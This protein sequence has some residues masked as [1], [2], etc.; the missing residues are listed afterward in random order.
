MCISLGPAEFKGTVIANFPQSTDNE[1]KRVLSYMNSVLSAGTS[2]TK[3][4]VDSAPNAMVFPVYGEVTGVL[5]CDEPVASREWLSKQQ[6]VYYESWEDWSATRSGSGTPGIEVAGNY[7]V[8]VAA[9]IEDIPRALHRLKREAATAFPSHVPEVLDYTLES[10]NRFYR[11][12]GLG[13]PQFVLAAFYLP[14]RY[15]DR[16]N[17]V[18]ITYTQSDSV[19]DK[20][21]FPALDYHGEGEFQEYVKRDHTLLLSTN[22][23]NEML[24]SVMHASTDSVPPEFNQAPRQFPISVRDSRNP[25]NELE[26]RA[27]NNDYMFDMAAIHAKLQGGAGGVR[28]PAPH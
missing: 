9:D 1:Q 24:G 28:S 20:L 14:P 13:I 7:L 15:I 10:M 25:R 23:L 6:G 26:G 2:P 5:D 11:A 16:K 3:E 8:S 17:P 12:Q 27:P 19:A 21:V 4:A 18:T 22:I